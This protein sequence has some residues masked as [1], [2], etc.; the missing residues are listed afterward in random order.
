MLRAAH[1][2]LTARGRALVCRKKYEDP[3][4]WDLRLG[5][6]HAVAPRLS[7]ST[8]LEHTSVGPASR[9]IPV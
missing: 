8:T 1:Q 7:N 6:S 5:L 4:T 3:R 2:R 9:K